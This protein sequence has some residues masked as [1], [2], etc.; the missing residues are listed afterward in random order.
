[1]RPSHYFGGVAATRDF[2]GGEAADLYDRYTKPMPRH[3]L[4][5]KAVAKSVSFLLPHNDC[6][7]VSTPVTTCIKHGSANPIPQRF[8]SSQFTAS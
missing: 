5:E 6:N 4:L 1:L 7:G 8:C 3:S 2:T